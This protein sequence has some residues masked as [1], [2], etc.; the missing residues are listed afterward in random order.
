MA[1]LATDAVLC[2]VGSERGKLERSWALAQQISKLFLS[3]NHTAERP[4][5][6][7]PSRG[8][9]HC[10]SWIDLLS[11]NLSLVVLLHNHNLKPLARDP[12]LRLLKHGN[13]ACALDLS[14]IESFG[15]E[16]DSEWLVR[17]FSHFIILTSANTNSVIPDVTHTPEKPSG[18]A[19]PT[20]INTAPHIANSEAFIVF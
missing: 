9:R 11:V 16:F 14:V 8:W 7:A 1:L 5:L 12:V 6:L 19:S 3:R 15:F 4:T 18:S 20:F 17:D 10:F 13:V 2:I